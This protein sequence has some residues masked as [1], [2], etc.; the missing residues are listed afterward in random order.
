MGHGEVS[1]FSGAR[2]KAAIA[3]ELATMERGG[4]R[5]PDGLNQYQKGSEVKVSNDPLT[6][7]QLTIEQA[8]ALQFV[9]IFD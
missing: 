1:F 5:N 8:A 3:A 6:N 7:D 4:N 9:Q 2:E